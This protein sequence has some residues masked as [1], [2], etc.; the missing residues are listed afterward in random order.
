MSPLDN[1]PKLAALCAVASVALG[2]A[3]FA[4]GR[5][6]NRASHSV[7]QLTAATRAAS[8]DGLTLYTEP[9]AGVKPVVE[10]IEAAR[11]SIELSIYELSDH[12]IERALVA[13]AARGVSVRVIL[14]K[15][16][17]EPARVNSL[18]RS[19]LLAHRVRVR[20]APPRY[21]LDHEKA[22]VIDGGCAFV[23][24]LNFTPE[25]YASDR[26][27]IVR[28]DRHA[29]VT[30]IELRFAE[31]WAAA[32]DRARRPASGDGA[33]K[34]DADGQA[35]A[36]ASKTP[37]VLSPGATP[38]L[39]ALLGSARKRVQVESEELEDPAIVAAL[40]ADARRGVNV[41]VTMTFE[42]SSRRSL[43]RVERCGDHVRLYAP[44]ARLYIHAKAI[45]VDRHTAFIGSQNLST[46]SLSYNRELG[47][48]FSAAA[49]VRSLSATLASDF[50]HA[51]PIG[52]Q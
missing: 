22:L 47:I 32:G 44:D 52:A 3:I 5:A 10:S 42:P 29:D 28:D 37:L 6:L 36:N 50:A 13:A 43:A 27:F 19:Y 30:T 14:D 49:L 17:Y 9:G 2:A 8:A 46:Q 45:V 31:D 25:Y 35:A 51:H 12:R 20:Y 15:H 26:D 1:R 38:R 23:M 11:R 34:G 4:D 16:G 41:E 24:T 33:D 21:A 40:C 48:V 7:R 18:A 39:L